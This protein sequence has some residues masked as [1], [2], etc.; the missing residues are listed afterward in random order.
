MLRA[1][2]IAVDID[3]V[4]CPFFRPMV[5]RVGRTPPTRAHPYV[6]HRALDITENE[7]KKM[8]REFYESE[9]F[10]NLQP[11]KDVEYAL[12]R[13]KEKGY[14]LYAMT[15]RQTVARDATETWLNTHF[16]YAFDDLVM[17][18]SYTMDEIPKSKLCLSMNI[19]TI[20]D[21][22][23]ETCYGCKTKGVK[24]INYIGDPVYP[25]CHA[26]DSGIITASNWLEVLNEFPS[27]EISNIPSDC[28]DTDPMCLTPDDPSHTPLLPRKHM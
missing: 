11:F 5:K 10:K 28:S 12:F 22:S 23:F 16:P 18:N 3:E 1:S 27:A 13:L 14:S 17:T 2:R 26:R 7:S 6:Y 21:D 19:S 8:V 24:A 4:L 25:W 9:E 20:I 15:G